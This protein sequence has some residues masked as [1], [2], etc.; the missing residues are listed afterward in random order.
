MRNIF[1]ILF[2]CAMFLIQPSVSFS[3]DNQWRFSYLDSIPSLKFLNPE[4]QFSGSYAVGK[5]D[6]DISIKDCGK[7][8][9]QLCICPAAGFRIATLGIEFLFSEDELPTRSEFYLITSKDHMVSDVVAYILGVNRRIDNKKATY[10]VD[11]AILANY[12]EWHYYIVRK[13][14]MKACQI[15]YVKRN[16]IPDEEN[17][18]LKSI[19]ERYEKGRTSDEEEAYFSR[20]M[21]T[22]VESILRGEEDHLFI[23]K[24]FAYEKLKEMCPYLPDLESR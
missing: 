10:F 14:N 4:G 2:S 7:Y 12:R 9:G 6:I 24:P 8:A 15:V 20:R 21:S 16:L 23:V 22:L 17:E 11:P 18:R 13:D 3:Q 5:E 1:I 19:E